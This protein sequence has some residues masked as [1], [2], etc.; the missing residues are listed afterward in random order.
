MVSSPVRAEDDDADSPSTI[1]GKISRK[2]SRRSGG[3]T[4]KRL[5]NLK[6]FDDLLEGMRSVLIPL[7]SGLSEAEATVE[8]KKAEVKSIENAELVLKKIAEEKAVAILLEA[9]E[10][11]KNKTS[12]P[13]EKELLGQVMREAQKDKAIILKDLSKFM[14]II[15]DEAKEGEPSA[16]PKADIEKQAAPPTTKAKDEVKKTPQEAAVILKRE[17]KVLKSLEEKKEK[18]LGDQRSAEASADELKKAIAIEVQKE[19]RQLNAV[20]DDFVKEAKKEAL[21]KKK[22]VNEVAKE[23]EQKAEVELRKVKEEIK[24]VAKFDMKD[25]ENEAVMQVEKK[26]EAKLSEFQGNFAQ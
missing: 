4:E 5:T 12:D 6:V 9:V 24:E 21:E 23:L 13:A 22:D 15:N 14:S 11:L 1:A 20:K 18:A 19:E 3:A 17:Q 7:Q 16:S 8:Q 10:D 25:A 2:R 26:A